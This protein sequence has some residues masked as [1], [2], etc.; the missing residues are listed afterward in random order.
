[1]P[2]PLQA[3]IDQHEYI[4]SLLNQK[5]AYRGA[6]RALAVNTWKIKQCERL[7]LSQFA[8]ISKNDMELLIKKL[9]DANNNT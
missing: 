7:Y 6:K 3:T 4:D 2:K 5:Y 8:D 9:E 1:M